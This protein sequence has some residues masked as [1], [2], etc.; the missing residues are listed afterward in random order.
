MDK[1][2]I[3]ILFFVKFFWAIPIFL[4]LLCFA[5]CFLQ[6]DTDYLLFKP[7]KKY[8]V[9]GVWWLN[10]M[11]C[12]LLNWSLSKLLIGQKKLSNLHKSYSIRQ[13]NGLLI[14]SDIDRIWC[15]MCPTSLSHDWWLIRSWLTLVI[16]TYRN[17]GFL[18]KFDTK[19]VSS[20]QTLKMIR[21][22]L[23]TLLSE[24]P[25]NFANEQGVSLGTK[26]ACK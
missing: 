15:A 16:L 9:F 5:L 14:C 20:A 13:N 12:E 26:K 18:E 23:C 8:L 24:F 1:F 25:K 10:S 2:L 6:I 19:N 11:K 21:W 22:Y 7:W 3:N 4:L 17:I